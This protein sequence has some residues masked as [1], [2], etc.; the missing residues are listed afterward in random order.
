M[1]KIGTVS[2]DTTQIEKDLKNLSAQDNLENIQLV[3]QDAGKVS[4]IEEARRRLQ[5]RKEK[6]A[7][8]ISDDRT[9]SLDEQLAA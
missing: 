6:L 4:T 1:G 5:E 2:N 3:N 8:K 9:F 7:K